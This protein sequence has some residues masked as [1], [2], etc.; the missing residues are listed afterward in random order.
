[1]ASALVLAPGDPP[2]T[3]AE[4]AAHYRMTE[5]QL[6]QVIRER[7]V[8][9]LRVGHT[10]RFDIHALN[11]LEE[12]MRCHA[13]EQDSGSSAGPTPARSRS[14][15]RSQAARQYESALRATI[16]GS[17]RKKLPSSKPSSCEPNGT[18]RVVAIGPSPRR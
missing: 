4:V 14:S 2:L 5:R 3:L 10:V 6:R 1:M 18:G 11:S 9:V 8:E 7:A 16:L 15:A 12:K 13:E 17:R